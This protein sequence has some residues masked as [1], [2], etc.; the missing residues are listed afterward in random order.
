MKNLV[1]NF[2]PLRFLPYRETG[3]FVNVGVVVN[4]PQVDFFGFRVIPTR[5]TGRVTNFFPELDAPLLRAALHRTAEELTRV[6]VSHRLFPTNEIISPEKAQVQIAA[7][8]ELVRRREGLLHFGETG[9][10]L[11]EDPEE[12]VDELF[13]RFVERQFAQRKEYQENV[14]RHRLAKFLRQWNLADQYE[15]NQKVGDEDFHVIIPFVHRF[16][17]TIERAIKPLDL[18]KQDTSDIYHHGGAWVKNMER[19]A[20]RSRMPKTTVF[21]VRMPADGKRLNAAE[22]I[23]N[24]LRLIGIQ[25]VPFGETSKLRE[26]AEV[27][28]AA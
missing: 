23:C 15:T 10:L 2:A 7:F 22:E 14:M 1:C 11:A 8:Q 25:A 18:D 13:S 26:L 19:L 6:Q 16:E 9:M 24:E 20:K 12:A 4:C 3:E 28:K 21:A 17:A 27:S 5:R